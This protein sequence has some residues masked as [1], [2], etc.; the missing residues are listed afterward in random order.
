MRA[1]HVLLADNDEDFLATCA[2]YLERAHYR[3]FRAYSPAQVREVL[4]TQRIHLAV[5]D[6]RMADETPEDKSGLVLARQI[7]LN[8]PKIILTKFPTHQ[9]ARQALLPSRP[10]GPL[11]LDFIDKRDGLPALLAAVECAFEQHVEINWSQVVQCHP[12]LSLPAI[13]SRLEPK[14]GSQVLG[15]RVE[16]FEDLLGKLFKTE[17]QVILERVLWQDRTRLALN[18]L[19][20]KT[21]LGLEN[22]VVVV[23]VP[24]E[25]QAEA[26]NYKAFAPQASSPHATLLK[27]ET[28]TLHWAANAY[29]LAGADA[30]NMPSLIERY[31]EGTRR[32]K[33][34][35]V[36]LYQTVLTEWHRDHPIWKE[37]GALTEAYGQLLGVTPDRLPAERF[38]QQVLE[39]IQ[40]MPALGAPVELRDERLW[41][42]ISR[43]QYDYPSPAVLPAEWLAREAHILELNTPGQ[44]SGANLLTDSEGHIWLTDFRAAGPA[45]EWWPF[46]SLEADIRFGWGEITSLPAWHAI[47]VCLIQSPFDRIKLQEVERPYHRLLEAIQIIRDQ[48]AHLVGTNTRAYEVGL[49]WCALK[50]VAEREAVALEL[51]DELGRLAHAVL[52]LAMLRQKI[53]AQASL[54]SQPAERGLRMD[55]AQQSLSVDGRQVEVTAKEFRWLY[56]LYT[57]PGH[58]CN[59]EEAYRFLYERE[60]STRDEGQF[61]TAVSRL[62]D[63]LDPPGSPYRHLKT[64]RGTGYA[65]DPTFDD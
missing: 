1:K 26:Q 12:T 46:V 54:A 58:L 29:L 28:Q 38:R 9:D 61:Y 49:L 30:G 6:L 63:K 33:S 17:M 14:G 22:W 42:P 65:L 24:S 25:I 23:G 3:V 48:A 27:R 40:R 36:P 2:E 55:E 5:F 16:E 10:G 15:E 64:H 53:E 52:A 34:A 13:V 7:E 11:A 62:R 4:E 50:R 45:P 8:L 18:V 59:K 60:Y 41:V 57:L 43:F 35:V 21:P 47:E 20:S 37:G 31:K 32:L 51:P 19:V 44:L 39:I 56:H